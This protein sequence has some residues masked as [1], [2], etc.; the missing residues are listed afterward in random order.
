MIRD[1]S[2][3]H[4]LLA[5]SDKRRSGD[6]IPRTKLH[7]AAGE[8]QLSARFE[9]NTPYS[10]NIPPFAAGGNDETGRILTKYTHIYI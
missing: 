10:I 3:L 2:N 4:L 5:K 7:Q 8:R 9:R 6:R 1:I